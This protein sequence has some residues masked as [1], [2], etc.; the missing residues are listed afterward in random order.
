MT[1]LKSPLWLLSTPVC[2]GAMSGNGEG[3]PERA[4]KIVHRYYEQQLQED[5]GDSGKAEMAKEMNQLIFLFRSCADPPLERAIDLRKRADLLSSKKVELANLFDQ[6]NDDMK[7]DSFKV[8]CS[9]SKSIVLHIPT[10]RMSKHS[11]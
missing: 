8:L 5:P 4:L 3:K 11:L 1:A 9:Q 2:S 7:M 6:L 10:L